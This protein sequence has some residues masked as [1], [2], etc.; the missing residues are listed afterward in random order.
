MTYLLYILYFSACQGKSEEICVLTLYL[1][2]F[3]SVLVHENKSFVNHIH[4]FEHGNIDFSDQAN[5]S[6]K[7]STVVLSEWESCFESDL[8]ALP[9]IFL[10]RKQEVSIHI[11]CYVNSTG[12][13][14]TH[15][16]LKEGRFMS[17]Q[18]PVKIFDRAF[19]RQ[20]CQEFVCNHMTSRNSTPS[21]VI[22]YTHLCY[23]KPMWLPSIEHEI[24]YLEDFLSY[25]MGID[26]WELFRNTRH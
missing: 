5:N 2:F 17:G 24:R 18:C 13:A 19:W 25:V 1:S 6:N 12:W 16:Y 22:I 4:H 9:P 15:L 11:I 26:K 3:N 7:S 10:Q 20:H 14:R 23:L 8:I 21:N